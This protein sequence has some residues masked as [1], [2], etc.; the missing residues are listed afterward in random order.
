M[1]EA[2]QIDGLK[3]LASPYVWDWERIE[4][5]APNPEELLLEDEDREAQESRPESAEVL[6]V[7]LLLPLLCDLDRIIIATVMLGGHSQLQLA[8]A[9]GMSQPAI[10]A[11]I[12]RLRWWIPYVVELRL[13]LASELGRSPP[14]AFACDPIRA[15]AYNLI[16]WHHRSLTSVAHELGQ[17]QGVFSHQVRRWQAQTCS[18]ALEEI[19]R[20]PHDWTHR[21]GHAGS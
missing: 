3:C 2:F 7:R 1:F 12:Q 11:R 20:N 16:V 13:R 18:T 5:P 21:R 10:W 9:L 8:G 15:A 4:S 6:E 14:P 17:A 19:I